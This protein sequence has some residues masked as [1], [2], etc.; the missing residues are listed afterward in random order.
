MC[1]CFRYVENLEQV[2]IDLLSSSYNLH[3]FRSPHTGVWV[4][5]RGPHQM[6]KICALGVRKARSKA[7]HEKLFPPFTHCLK[8]A[9]QWPGDKPWS[10]PQL[11]HRHVLVW[12]DCSLWHS[13]IVGLHARKLTWPKLSGCW[14][15]ITG[16]VGEGRGCFCGYSWGKVDWTLWGNFQLW[17]SWYGGW[18]ES[19]IP[20]RIMT[21]GSHRLKISVILVEGSQVIH[22]HWLWLDKTMSHIMQ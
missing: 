6:S 18:R 3:G 11:H 9:Q 17:I 20:G 19:R 22:I 12:S 1:L 2:V 7:F 10:G 5:T 8:G 21:D 16:P 4:Q 14:G 13:G 15:Y